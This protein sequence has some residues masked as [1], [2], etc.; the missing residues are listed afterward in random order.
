MLPQIFQKL[1]ST[2]D[3]NHTPSSL[4]E[5]FYCPAQLKGKEKINIS[6]IWHQTNTQALVNSMLFS[7]PFLCDQD[8]SR[9]PN[10]D[11]RLKTSTKDYTRT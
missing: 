6:M 5:Q 8:I 9:T 2:R 7:Y 1:P 3:M 10:R 11:N 4:A